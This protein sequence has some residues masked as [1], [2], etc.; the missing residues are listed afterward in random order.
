MANKGPSDRFTVASNRRA[1]ANYDILDTYE[2][3]I[4]LQGS[5]VKSLRAG[6]VQLSDAFARVRN[7]EMWILGMQISPWSHSSA[8]NGHVVDRPRKLLLHRVEIDRL[9][10][11]T[12]QDPLQLIP[13]SVYFLD[14]RAKL[15]LALARGRRQYDKRHA[16]RKR[17][18]DLEARRAMA[19]RNR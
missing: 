11:R 18:S 9:R 7:H 13:L 15:E 3:G 14:G 12:E 17:E 1:R 5:E 16:I 19:R 6:S 2:C 8:H 4:V 10:A